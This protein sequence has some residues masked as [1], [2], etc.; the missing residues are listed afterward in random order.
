VRSKPEK[1][2]A[3]LLAEESITYEYEPEVVSYSATY[4]PDFRLIVGSTKWDIEIKQKLNAAERKIVSE[5]A[6][7]YLRQERYYA[8]GVCVNK[9]P[10]IRPYVGDSSTSLPI[11]N[12]YSLCNWLEKHG[13]TWFAYNK[14]VHT[15]TIIRFLQDAQPSHQERFAHF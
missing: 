1:L 14:F 7:D 10:S 12:G 2:F 5:V 4:R 11:L 15:S 3:S 8:V 13:I 9:A 6:K